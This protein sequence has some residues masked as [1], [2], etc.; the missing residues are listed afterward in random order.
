METYRGKGDK[1]NRQRGED[2]PGRRRETGRDRGGDRDRQTDRQTE[3]DRE[4][5]IKMRHRLTN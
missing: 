4:R 1:R 3:R 5:Q 2:K